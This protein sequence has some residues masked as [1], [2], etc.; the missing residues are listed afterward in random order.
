MT[1]TA[2]TRRDK[3]RIA[4][5]EGILRAALSIAERD[6]WPAVTIRKIAEE[7]EYTSPIIYQHFDNKEAALQAVMEGGY[8][9]LEAQLRRA[10]TSADPEVRLLELS[11]AYLHFARDH[12]H[13]YE[14]MHGLGGVSLD[15][16]ARG[17]AAAGAVT[18]TTGAVSAWADLR[19]AHIDPLRASET[20]W[21][22]LH[23]MASL[24]LL[25]DIGFERAEGLAVDALIALLR[26]W[27]ADA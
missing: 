25:P 11:R 13:V 9:D 1:A 6:G 27:E 14:L 3:Q 2:M 10:M 20:A 8:G 5:R 21:G 26:S 15:P 7:I 24:G 12:R 16:R 22:V 23:G 19:H 17:G 4:N 18:L